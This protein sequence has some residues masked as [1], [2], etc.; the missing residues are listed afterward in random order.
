MKHRL[1]AID[2]RVTLISAIEMKT[3]PKLF[4]YQLV[5]DSDYVHLLT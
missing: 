3:S 4:A 5:A 1:N 2:T